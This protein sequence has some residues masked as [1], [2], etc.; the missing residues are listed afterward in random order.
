MASSLCAGEAQAS[1]LACPRVSL[2]VLAVAVKRAVGIPK[3]I[4]QA[5]HVSQLSSAETPRETIP[6][7]A[8]AVSVRARKPWPPPPPVDGL[9]RGGGG[10][11]GARGASPPT[12]LEQRRSRRAPA[13]KGAVCEHKRQA[14]RAAGPAGNGIVIHAL[15]CGGVN[16]VGDPRTEGRECARVVQCGQQ[17]A[18]ELAMRVEPCA[19][20]GRSPPT[21]AQFCRLQHERTVAIRAT[22]GREPSPN[23]GVVRGLQGLRLVRQPDLGNPND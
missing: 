16:G 6:T 2:A 17:P 14:G 23:D 7:R 13:G 5:F 4:P 18:K 20:G 11:G 3:W 22:A 19:P 9:R 10:A 1:F 15:W 8:T 12:H 21:L